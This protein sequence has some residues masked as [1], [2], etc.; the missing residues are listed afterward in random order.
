MALNLVKSVFF[1]FFEIVFLAMANALPRV[2]IFNVTRYALLRLAGMQIKGQCTIFGPLTVRP[3]GGA[4]N[5]LI[6]RKTF[7]NAEISFG[8]P[9]EKIIIGDNVQIGPR[10][11]FETVNHEIAYTPGMKRRTQ[12]QPIHIADGAWIGA[13]AII[14]PGITIG[15]GAVVAAGAVVTQDVPSRTVVGGV[16]AKFIK[17]IEQLEQN[18]D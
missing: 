13:G 5:I 2:K 9:N 3:A 14:L 16:P 11:L 12:S 15:E 8:C 10:V 7:L 1:T 4:R 6:G 18:E 17:K